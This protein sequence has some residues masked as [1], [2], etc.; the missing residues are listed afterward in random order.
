VISNL[1]FVKDDITAEMD[2]LGNRVKN[3]VDFTIC[4][5]SYKKTL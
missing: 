1:L 2:L 4:V 5:V 3:S